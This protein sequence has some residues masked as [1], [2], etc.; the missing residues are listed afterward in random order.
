MC[1][2]D[3]LASVETV[4]AAL[5]GVLVYHEQIGLANLAGIALVMCSILMMNRAFMPLRKKK[6][7]QENT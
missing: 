6:A 5:L 1:I 4:A 7:R 3:R 2:R